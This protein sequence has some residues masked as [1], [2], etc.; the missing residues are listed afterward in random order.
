MLA[1]TSSPGA[2]SRLQSVMTPMCGCVSDPFWDQSGFLTAPGLSPNCHSPW[3]GLGLTSA[4]RSRVAAHWSSWA[5]CIHMI[6][7]RHLSVAETLITGIHRG[8]APCFAAVRSRQGTLEEVGLIP[9]W[10]TLV[11]TPPQREDAEPAEPKVGWQHRA[12]RCLEDQ[13][14][15][16]SCGPLSQTLSAH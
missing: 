12:T 2:L 6:R 4:V 15:G 3:G 16:C 10:R 9:S 11:D 1:A 14:S 13:P 5:D 8:P 7:Q